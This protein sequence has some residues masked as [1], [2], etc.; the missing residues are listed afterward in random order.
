MSD[1]HVFDDSRKHPK[2]FELLLGKKFKIEIWE[3]ALNTMFVRE[4][5]KF[6]VPKE[7]SCCNITQLI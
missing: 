1:G 2:P 3:L 5:A 7:V 6:I 4:V